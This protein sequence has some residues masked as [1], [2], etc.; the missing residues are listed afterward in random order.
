MLNPASLTL[1]CL[2]SSTLGPDEKDFISFHQPAGV[3]LFARNL[4]DK[5]KLGPLKLVQELQ[6]CVKKNGSP[7]IVAMD[8]EGGL[9]ARMKH[10]VLDIGKAF[11][12][13]GGGFDTKAL[14]TIEAIAYEQGRAL[15]G[16]GV[17]VNF[18]PV[19]DVTFPREQFNNCFVNSRSFGQTKESVILRAG[20]YLKGLKR[21]SVSSCLKHFPGIGRISGDSHFVSVSENLSKEFLWQENLEPFRSLHH[22]APMIMAAHLIF[23]DISPL[24]VTRSS[25]W[26]RDILRNEFGF[27]GLI[28]CDDLTMKAVPQEEGAWKDFVIETVLAGCDLLLICYGLEKWQMACDVLELEIKKS[29]TFKRYAEASSDRLQKFRQKL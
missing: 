24:E 23:R 29:P 10:P 11:D 15:L 5:E 13:C 3:T 9:V 20:A 14:N 8:Q 7:F 27:E 2:E 1:G 17:N 22:A 4:I 21:A 28:L 25:F 12:L 16:L 18:A 26:L 6:A 19:L